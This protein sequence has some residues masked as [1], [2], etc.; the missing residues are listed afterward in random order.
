MKKIQALILACGICFAAKAQ[1]VAI[2]PTGDGGFETGIDLS[3]NNWTA[4]NPSTT[5]NQWVVNNTATAYAGARGVHVSNDGTANTYTTTVARACHFLRDVTIPAGADL[6]T[7][8]FYWKGMG[9]VGF[10]RLLVYTAP[11]SIVPAVNA[12]VSP[13]TGIGGATLVWQQSATSAAYS[14]ATVTLPNTLAGTTV[15]LIFTWQNDATGGTTPGA[16]IDNISLT[17]VCATPQPITGNAPVC[18]GGSV[19]VGNVFAGGTWQS[20]NTAIATVTSGGAVTGIAAGTTSITYTSGSC[21]S[22]A[23]VSVSPLPL[24]ITGHDSVCV[25][26]TTTFADVVIGGSWSSN[27]PVIA[28][29]LS[30]SGVITGHLAGQAFITYTMP[31]G[32]YVSDTVTVVNNPGSITGALQVCPGTTT[33]LSCAP[34]GGT[35]SSLNPGSASINSTGKVT[36]IVADTAVIKYTS[37]AGC[38]S[39]AVVTINPLPAPIICHS[40]MC[41][42]GMDTAYN[43]TAGGIWTSLTP[44]LLTINPTTG[45]MSPS[46]AGTAT[47]KYTMA[48]AC[49]VTRSITLNP[50]PAVNVHFHAPSNTLYT[51]T[52]Y[53]AYQWYHDIFGK[54]IGATSFRT[55]GLYNGKYYVEV[56]DTN[57]CVGTSPL[58][59]Y[60]TDMGVGG[61]AGSGAVQV[62]PNPA[63]DVLHISATVPCNAVISSMDGKLIMSAEKVH[64][65][66]VSGLS[67]GLYLLTVYD[68]EGRKLAIERFTRR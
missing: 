4:V 27:Y 29:V 38:S 18:I 39:F 57:G 50:L 20:Q 9:Q 47:I 44:S 26:S 40:V 43:A 10:D 24:P 64:T 7:L 58:F 51:D 15:R 32:C 41:A 28:S 21:V 36:G 62:Y 5:A 31:G 37:A 60:N 2:S 3:T 33:N 68:E 54:V 53:V 14:L 30:G 19:S 34:S 23:V 16:A 67:A 49:A 45:E 59:N 48:T 6:I 13:A 1:I 61:L 12:P 42:Q 56:T 52:P 11:S 22:T 8:S 55:A 63:T 35:W 17:Y 46:A 25:G 65:M 66:N